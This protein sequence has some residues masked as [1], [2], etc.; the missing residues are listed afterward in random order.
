MNDLALIFALASVA[1]GLVLHVLPDRP[2]RWFSM[3]AAAAA[4]AVW[5]PLALLWLLALIAATWAAMRGGETRGH[6]DLPVAL[7]T[8]AALA[9]LLGLREL[10]GIVWLGGAYFTL[11]NLHVLF[12]WWRGRGV[13]PTL[14]DLARYNLF[15]PVLVAGPI[16]RFPE[17]QRE[18][19]RRRPGV[20]DL[21][22]G[23]ER[24][25]MGLASCVVLATRFDDIA[26]EP[27]RVIEVPSF[28]ARWL[29][30]ACDWVYL[31]F[32]FAGLSAVAIGSARMA[33][34]KIEENFDHPWRARDLAGFWLRW[35]MSLSFWVRD[36]VYQPVAVA[37]RSPVA[38]VAAAMLAMGLWH[39]TSLHYV[40]WA[41]WQAAGIVVSH[42]VLRRGPPLPRRIGGIVS[43]VLILG[44]LSLAGPV[45]ALALGGGAP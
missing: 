8:A 43:P 36:Y 4:L 1:T 20:E 41:V 13:A 34:L 37:M 33:G 32:V 29:L 3:I 14:A 7:V 39:E 44:W 2:A 15:L 19:R 27:L 28:M 45:L 22:A 16:H 42:L 23:A 17:F 38:G 12:D 30:S 9:A 40:L 35:H 18:W 5:A 6:R 25:L 26:R 10:P 11:R 24:V 31:F 21:A